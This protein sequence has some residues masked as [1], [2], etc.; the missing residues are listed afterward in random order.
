MKTKFLVIAVSVAVFS[1]CARA[2]QPPPPP[3]FDQPAQMEARKL[4]SRGDIPGALS[5][6]RSMLY[7]KGKEIWT[8]QALLV[9]DEKELDA[10]A[11]ALEEASS[12]P[13][14]VI[15][16]VIDSK[17]CFRVCA[18]V[19]GSKQEAAALTQRLPSPF[20][21]A[22]PYPLLLVK[23]GAYSSGAF[24]DE[25]APS[26]AEGAALPVKTSRE[27]INAPGEVRSAAASAET[28]QV[29][30][31]A[32]DFFNRG[33]EAF[34]RND[35][36]EAES[37][38]KRSVELAPER[39]ESV[40][41]L[42]AVLLHQKKYSEARDVLEKAVLLK[43]GYPNAHSNLGGA[44]WFLGKRQEAIGEA[45]KAFRLDS[46]NV[47]Y[48]TNLASFLYEEKRYSDAQIY[49]N[50]VKIIDPENGD[51]L[52]LQRKIDEALGKRAQASAEVQSGE[53]ESQKAQT[54]EQE[55]ARPD[56]EA[57]ETDKRE[58]KQKV[59]AGKN[60]DEAAPDPSDKPRKRFWDKFKKRA[61]D[62]NDAGDRN[63]SDAGAVATE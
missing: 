23:N 24:G 49:L 36:Q 48:C 5:G 61:A 15:R 51:A 27:E 8:T 7:L 60:D 45:Q 22:K 62:K 58:K 21:E 26:A 40:N 2:Q 19:F 11:A 52:A 29:G 33:L 44:Y 59:E 17:T 1:V 6:F 16:R 43:P 38:F 32:Q 56:A 37:L 12:E 55:S 25:P 3:L 53:T 9:C 20:R 39:F 14:I 50:V 46:H 31:A 42:G 35:L 63:D 57:T 34:N 4:L 18:G 10:K 13:L 47:R 54:G 30:D 28:L 41:N